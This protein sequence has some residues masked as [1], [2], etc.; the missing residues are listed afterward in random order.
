MRPFATTVLALAS[1]ATAVPAFAKPPFWDTLVTGP[2]RFKVL[3]AFASEAVLDKETGIV[4][5]RTPGAGTLCSAGERTWSAAQACCNAANIGGRGGWRLPSIHELRTVFDPT[6]M[7]P[8]LPAG[9]PFTIGAQERFWSAT[10][11]AE[12]PE[13]ALAVT[14]A[15]GGVAAVETDDEQAHLWCV[16]AP[17]GFHHN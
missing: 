16:R 14:V 12:V 7:S 15:S 5:Q 4:W 1:L 6:E 13:A 10:E 9:H 17:G 8:A 11:S 2:G 3:P